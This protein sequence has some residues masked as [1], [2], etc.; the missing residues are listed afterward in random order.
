MNERFVRDLL[1]DGRLRV[2]AAPN[3]VL[4][5]NGLD[6]LKS[7]LTAQSLSLPGPPIRGSLDVLIPAVQVV[8]RFAWRFLNPVAIPADEDVSLRMN[9]VPRTAE[10]HLGGDLAFRFLPGLLQRA[11]NRDPSDDLAKAM[12]R[13]LREWPLSGV[14]A[15]ISDLPTTSLE[16]GGHPGVHF[17]YAE[18]LATRERAGWFPEGFG[19]EFVEVVWQS[20][21]KSLA[22]VPEQSRSN[23][24]ATKP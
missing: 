12:K 6:E 11:M 2:G 20:L 4:S 3:W 10:E 13:L 23:H 15:D 19:R 22:D 1:T 24:E 8:Y 16:F 18:R 17:L 5:D 14:L 9:C 7:A 21:G